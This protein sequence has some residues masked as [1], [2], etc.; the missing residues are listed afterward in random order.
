MHVAQ[1]LEAVE[2]LGGG[3]HEKGNFQKSGISPLNGARLRYYP[4]GL[5]VIELGNIHHRHESGSIRSRQRV[6]RLFL[7]IRRH[8]SLISVSDPQPTLSELLKEMR[9]VNQT[10][11]EWKEFC[12]SGSAPQ[13]NAACAQAKEHIVEAEEL[14]EEMQ[15]ANGT[16][17]SILNLDFYLFLWCLSPKNTCED[18]KPTSN[19]FYYDSL[20]SSLLLHP[21]TQMGQTSLREISLNSDLIRKK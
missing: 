13:I 5:K 4:I 14:L 3:S 15:K 11:N 7:F 21:S 18:H 6:R 12:K 2:K 9:S 1:D 16:R 8:S 19:V 20:V 17:I 10:Y